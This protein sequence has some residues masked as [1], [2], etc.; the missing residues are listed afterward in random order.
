M[1][2][3]IIFDMYR[4]LIDSE[5]LWQQVE[6]RVLTAHGVPVTPTMCRQTMGMRIDEVVRYWDVRYPGMMHDHDVVVDEIMHAVIA[7]VREKGV[8]MPGVDDVVQ[9]FHAQGVPMAIAS[10]SYRVLIDA[11]VEKLHL[12]P[13]LAVVHS[14]QEELYGKPHPAVFLATAKK[15]DVDPTTC[16]VF[17][18]SIN[19]VIAAKAARMTCVCVPDTAVKDHPQT[20]IADLVI[21]SLKQF[22]AKEWEKLNGCVTHR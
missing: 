4:L 10:S 13:Y 3:A 11:V 2:Q 15:L 17:E 5:P 6:S 14:A 8:M 19:G 18:D 12:A 22:G 21:S 20:A 16:L 7:L 9:F 1:I